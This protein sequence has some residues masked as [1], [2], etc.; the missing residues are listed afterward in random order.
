MTYW[1]SA[2]QK[3]MAAVLREKGKHEEAGAELFLH[4]NS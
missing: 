2:P 3:L 4:R 1:S